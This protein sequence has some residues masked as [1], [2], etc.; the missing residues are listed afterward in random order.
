MIPPGPVVSADWL[1]EHLDLV[2]LLDIRWYLADLG[3]GRREY[4]RDHLPGA[5]FVDLESDVSGEAGRGRHPL[6]S[7]AQFA[8]AM[9]R[10]GVDNATPVVVYDQNIG[11]VASRLWWLLRH[12]GHR[13]AAVLD[14]G[15]EAWVAAGL[16]VSRRSVDP[17]PAT[18]VASPRDGDM[19]MR[20]DLVEQL[21][22]V[23]LIDARAP[24]RYRGDSE[25]IDAKAG[26]IPTAINIPF[27][28]S[29]RNG[30]FA[31][32]NEL[33]SLLG[34]TE[35]AVVYCGSGVTACHTILAAAHADLPL[36]IL[37]EGSWSDW[38]STD[39]PIAVGSDV[40]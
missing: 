14:G 32:A 10:A 13:R 3:Q 8:A 18:F 12:F 16:P 26:H 34:D 33:V 5:V 36:P 6:P 37:Y 39:L 20:E 22:T 29:A 38:A 40:E 27:A 1:A 23:R 4:E 9:G 7:P 24:E 17:E 11:A 2:S 25:P 31:S 28:Q 21:G 35:G 30:R 19:V 15:Y